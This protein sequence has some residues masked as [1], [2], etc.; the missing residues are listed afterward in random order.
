MTPEEAMFFLDN[1]SDYVE[2]N[3]NDIMFEGS[4]EM[5]ASMKR[6]IFKLGKN[7]FNSDIGKYIKKSWIQERIDNGL[8]VK[9]VDLKF[10]GDLEDSMQSI[11][12]NKGANIEFVNYYGVTIAEK[13]ELLQGNKAG[14]SRMDIFSPSK[15]ELK[16]V[17]DNTEKKYLSGFDDIINSYQ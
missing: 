5:E 1:I 14:A 8:Q 3:T 16:Q 10:S 7:A 9:Y 6:R 13:Q 12:N 17:E 2:D 15:E 11:A 4:K